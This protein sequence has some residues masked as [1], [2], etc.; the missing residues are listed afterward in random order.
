VPVSVYVVDDHAIVRD[1]LLQVLSAHPEF[2]P[3]GS[4]A[5]GAAAVADI[6][7][8][9]PQVVI[10]DISLPDADGIELVPRI[11]SAAPETAIVMLS[12]HA[13]VDFVIRALEAGARG[14]VLKESASDNILHAARA[15]AAGER[16]LCPRVA[17]ILAEGL[18][19]R[20]NALGPESLSRREQEILRLVADGLTS[21]AIG[22]R[23]ELSQKTV[24]TY[25]SRLM[26]KLGISSVAG[27]VKYAL[28]HGLTKLE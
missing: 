15:V 25:R 7:R 4:A 1:G 20:R 22:T 17:A 21:A 12:M 8:L 10:L 27:L 3:V 28:L 11:L 5:T 18:G 2:D 6:P 19:A 13:G 23:L 16:Y 26:Q 24:D 9:H 14:Y